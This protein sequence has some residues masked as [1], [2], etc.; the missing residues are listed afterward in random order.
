MT[1]SDTA[2]GQVFQQEGG[3]FLVL[4]TISHAQLVTSIRVCNNNVNIVSNS[5][6]FIA[7]PFKFK[8]PE[9]REGVSP[10]AKLT[11][12]N[13]TREIIQAIRQIITPLDITVQ[14]VRIDDLDTVESSLPTFKLRNVGWDATQI[15]GDLTLDDVTKEPFPARSYTPSEYPGVFK[16]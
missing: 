11:I 15:T 14:V 16:V 12:D 5:N 4:L 7:Y 6:T 9:E 2:R 13:V 10:I 8:P 3:G 1:I